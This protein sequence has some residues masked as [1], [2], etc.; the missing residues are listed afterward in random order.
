MRFY[1]QSFFCDKN[2]GPVLHINIDERD[3]NWP[4][5]ITINHDVS[6]RYTA[7]SVSFHLNSFKDLIKFKNSVI[8]QYE[9]YL[10]SKEAK[11]V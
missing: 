5:T 11:D 3:K 9:T 1:S 6:A 10:R 2:K 4:I 7:P 8:E